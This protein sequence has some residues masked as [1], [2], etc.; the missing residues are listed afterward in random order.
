MRPVP[1]RKRYL[2]QTIWQ[3][4]TLCNYCISNAWKQATTVF[5]FFS[6][7]PWFALPS[8]TAHLDVLISG[9]QTVAIC[10]HD[11]ITCLQS[12]LCPRS[13]VISARCLRTALA[14][15]RCQLS[16]H[17][18]LKIARFGAR[19]SRGNKK[20][21]SAASTN[22]VTCRTIPPHRVS[23]PEQRTMLQP[24]LPEA[25]E[26][27]STR[28]KRTPASSLGPLKRCPAAHLSGLPI[29]PEV[30]GA[31]CSSLSRQELSAIE[32][33]DPASESLGVACARLRT[34]EPAGA[35]VGRRRESNVDCP[36]PSLL[37]PA[38]RPRP[39]FSSPRFCEHTGCKGEKQTAPTAS[40]PTS[41]VSQSSD[42]EPLLRFP[43]S[44]PAKP[45]LRAATQRGGR[46]HFRE[47][48]TVHCVYIVWA[49]Y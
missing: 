43:T 36:S 23:S 35:A 37:H 38:P 21:L 30:G 29:I 32:D 39:P 49:Q 4:H 15:C 41:H 28:R 19:K 45:A 22:Q 26:T 31:R 27:C 10:R 24:A 14:K 16:L 44:C 13:P 6:R 18:A 9:F 42:W 3:V 5:L 40:S 2:G 17:P 11:C 48:Q 7:L 33:R 12:E 46:R 1:H 47:R 34:R 25:S 8:S 20:S